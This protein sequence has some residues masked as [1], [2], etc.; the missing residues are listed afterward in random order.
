VFVVLALPDSSELGSLISSSSLL[1]TL[2]CSSDSDLRNRERFQ[3]PPC[4]HRRVRICTSSSLFSLDVGS[5]LSTSWIP[6]MQ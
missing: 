6:G 5:D 1:L 2:S 3:E 4:A